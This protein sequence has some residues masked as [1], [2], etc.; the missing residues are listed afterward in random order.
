MGEAPKK[1]KLEKE[2]GGRMKNMAVEINMAHKNN[3]QII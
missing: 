1:L 2:I 3:M